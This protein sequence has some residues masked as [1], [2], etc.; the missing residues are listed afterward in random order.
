MRARIPD[1]RKIT[2]GWWSKTL[3]TWE[4]EHNAQWLMNQDMTCGKLEAKNQSLL[5]NKR[6]E[7]HTGLLGCKSVL[8]AKILHKLERIEHAGS[9]VATISKYKDVKRSNELGGYGMKI[10]LR[11]ERGWRW[12]TCK[13]GLER[14]NQ[15]ML[16]E[17]KGR[18]SCPRS[19]ETSGCAEPSGGL[20]CSTD[21]VTWRLAEVE[22]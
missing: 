15:P 21:D 3:G 2:S 5:R 6:L 8:V 19:M 10:S 9:S 20:G 16:F 7:N 11:C 4:M 22:Y 14:E 17:V 18:G 13:A 12:V 1:L